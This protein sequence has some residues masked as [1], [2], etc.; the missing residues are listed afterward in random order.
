MLS[1]NGLFNVQAVRRLMPPNSQTVFLVSQDLGLTAATLYALKRQF[2]SNGAV[3]SA[4]SLSPDKW[5]MVFKHAAI[6]QM[7]SINEVER[8]TYFLEYEPYPEQLDAWKAAIVTCPGIFRPAKVRD[9]GSLTPRSGY[10]EI[11]IYERADCS[12]AGRG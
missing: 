2:E 8:S 12:D 5:D 10:E 1:F 6:I 4:R 11:K 7:A 9:N 3:V